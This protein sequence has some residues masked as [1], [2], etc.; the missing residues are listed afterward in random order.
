MRVILALFAAL[1][2]AACATD[3]G[4]RAVV[5]DVTGQSQAQ[6][7]SQD[8]YKMIQCAHCEADFQRV[9]LPSHYNLPTEDLGV[10]FAYVLD[11]NSEHRDLLLSAWM[12]CV[13]S[14]SDEENR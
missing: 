4:D 12:E 3:N 14:A 2:L 8:V 5:D 9:A 11:Q 10:C 6:A 7:V 13:E 1:V